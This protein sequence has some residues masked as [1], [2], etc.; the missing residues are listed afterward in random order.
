MAASRMSPYSAESSNP[1]TS[2]SQPLMR[3][4]KPPFHHWNVVFFPQG[5]IP[6]STQ[7]QLPE[8]GTKNGL[9]LYIPRGCVS[10]GVTLDSSSQ[11]TF[12]EPE[13]YCQVHVIK[14]DA[15]GIATTMIRLLNMDWDANYNDGKFFRFLPRRADEVPIFKEGKYRVDCTIF[16]TLGEGQWDGGSSMT[17]DVA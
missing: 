16:F 17:F 7:T 11:L 2:T 10:H 4:P 5:E 6:E 9:A 1:P 12:I 3:Q 13:T 15:E 14:C 8:A